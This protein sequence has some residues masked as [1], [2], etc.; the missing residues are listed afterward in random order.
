MLV[1]LYLNGDILTPLSQVWVILF[2]G[3]LTPDLVY[4]SALRGGR[5]FEEKYGIEVV[6]WKFVVFNHGR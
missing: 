3:C 1:V 6:R 5:G 4:A 2:R